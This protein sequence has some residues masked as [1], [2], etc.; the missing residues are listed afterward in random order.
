MHALLLVPA[1]ALLGLAT[2]FVLDLFADF[3]DGPRDRS[4]IF[5]AVLA[6][7]SLTSSV[8]FFVRALSP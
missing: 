1:F 7:V 8:V 6:A 3:S 4:W 5:V 2:L